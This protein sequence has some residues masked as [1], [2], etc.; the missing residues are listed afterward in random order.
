MAGTATV[1]KDL[2][3]ILA[4]VFKGKDDALT[5]FEKWLTTELTWA[6]ISPQDFA[7]LAEEEKQ[8]RAQ[9]VVPAAAFQGAA[10]KFTDE[11]RCIVPIKKA[12]AVCRA[13]HDKAQGILAGSVLA[14]QEDDLVPQLMRDDKLTRWQTKRNLILVLSRLPCTPLFSRMIEGV[15]QE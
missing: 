15:G 2:H 4:S 14:E 8:V 1:G 6:D 3:M 5:I 13:Q 11:S 9:I 12:W 10:G 7:L